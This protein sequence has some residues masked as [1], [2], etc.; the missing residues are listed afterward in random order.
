MFDSLR[1]RLALGT[2]SDFLKKNLE[3]SNQLKV[4]LTVDLFTLVPIEEVG[5]EKNGRLESSYE[6]MMLSDSRTYRESL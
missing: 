2:S 5:M 3:H 1:Q 4:L 6:I